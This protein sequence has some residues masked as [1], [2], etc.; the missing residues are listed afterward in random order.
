MRLSVERTDSSDSKISPEWNYDAD[1]GML[2]EEY[3]V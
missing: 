1:V 2:T 3:V